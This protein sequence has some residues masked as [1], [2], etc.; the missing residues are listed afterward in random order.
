MKEK[1]KKRVVIQFFDNYLFKMDAKELVTGT[2]TTPKRQPLIAPSK[3]GSSSKKRKI[4]PGV[5]REVHSLRSDLFS[6][7]EESIVP[8][9]PKELLK[10]KRKIAKEKVV[11]WIWGPF[12]N[13]ARRDGVKYNKWTKKTSPEFPIATPG[14]KKKEEKKEDTYRYA[15]FNVQFKVARYTGDMYAKHLQSEDWSKE[16][17]DELVELCERF[18]CRF[19]V[20]HDRFVEWARERNMRERTVEDLKE[21]FYFVC[22][23][24]E[25]FYP[26][27]KIPPPSS[28]G[29]KCV[30]LEN[31]SKFPFNR[32]W[33]ESRIKRA[34]IL[35]AK[36]PAQIEAESKLSDDFN[37]VQALLSK[38]E[39]DREKVLKLHE[40]IHTGDIPKQE[41]LEKL[42][43][44]EKE[45]EKEAPVPKKEKTFLKSSKLLAPKP[46]SPKTAA[47]IEAALK[48][49]GVTLSTN[50]T[51]GAQRAFEV[52]KQASILNWQKFGLFFLNF[53]LKDLLILL[54]MQK[55]IEN[56]EYEIRLRKAQKALLQEY[57]HQQEQNLEN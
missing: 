47:R 44:K 34:Q 9:P 38:L 35:F 41:K 3:K 27:T 17:T 19:P 57:L 16:E 18:D 13:E 55:K 20:V 14:G 45:K 56:K 31:V 36:S 21:R 49:L 42:K 1:E 54:E 7:Q 48:E 30:M 10:K 29:E 22:T 40:A 32:P 25:N 8:T 28:E 43:K 2:R 53:W 51:P 6:S 33:E 23:V 46:I 39:K 37:K 52:L 12:V 26:A 24:L 5:K 50:P 4:P 11:G 15:K